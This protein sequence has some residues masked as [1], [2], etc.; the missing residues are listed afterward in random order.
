MII[1]TS[2]VLRKALGFFLLVILLLPLSA[3]DI[4]ISEGGSTTLQVSVNTYEQLRFSTSL[5]KISAYKINTDAGMF[6]ELVVPGYSNTYVPGSPKLPVSRKLIEFPVGASAEVNILS[7]RVEEFDLADLGFEFQLMPAQPPAPKDG[8]YVAFEYDAEAYARNAFTANELVSVEVLGTMRGIRIARVD[9]SPIQY[10][11][12]SGKL[13]VYSEIEAEVLFNGADVLATLAEK[14]KNDAPYFRS[15]GANLINYKSET[16][17]NRDT[18]TKYPVKY[19]IVSDPMFETQLQ[20][21]IQWKT[22]KGFTV[23]EAYTD[24]PAVGNTTNSIK[25][26]L[27]GLY[28]AG[29]SSD[30]APSFVLFVGDVGQIPAWSGNSG[31]HVTDLLYV[32]F[33]GDYFPEIY[34]GR[35]SATN[36]AELQPQIDKTLQYEQYTMPDPSY[37]DEVVLVAGM[38]ATFGNDWANGQINYGTENYFNIAHGLT[39]HTYLYPNSGSHSADI[40]QNVSDGVSF[41]NYTAHCSA[42]G[43]ADPS[44]VISDIAG[45]QNQD[46]YCVLIGNCC[47]SSEF[48]N[49]CFAEAILRAENKGAVGYIGG[50]NST[51][52][53]P[54]Y[55]FGVGVGTISEDPPSYEET[56]LGNYDRSFHDHGEPWEDWYTTTYQIIFAGNLAVTQGSPGS[57][58]YY[59]EI[60]CVMGDPSLECYFGVPDPPNVTYDPL[61]PLGTT[62]FTVNT[63]PYAYVGISKDGVLHGSALADANGIAVVTLDP[64][65]TPGT[66]DV[67]VTKQNTQPYIGTV[68]V[69]IPSGPYLV[70]S[71]HTIVDATGNNNGL[72]DYGESILLDVQLEN[73]GAADANNVEA[74][75]TSGDAYVSITDNFALWGT[76]AAGDTSTI[77]SAYSF[78]VH[79][80]VPDQHISAFDLEITGSG[81]DTWNASFNVVLNAP[82]LKSGEVSVD[83]SQAGNSNGRLDPGETAEIV[84]PLMNHGHCDASNTIS[85]LTTNNNH[86]VIN[87]GSFNVGSLPTSDTVN[88]VFSITVD[89][90]ITAGTSV[91]FEYTADADGYTDT[92][93]FFLIAGQTPVLIV[94]LDPNSSSSSAMTACLSN[95]GVGAEYVNV[96]PDELEMYSSVF[97]CLGIYSNNHQL[98]ADEGQA[99]AGYLNNGGNLYMEGGDTWYYDTQ[100]AVH[101]MFGI[102]GLSDG[103]DDLSSIQGQDGT[104]TE[105]MLYTYSGENNWID[106][107][108]PNGDAFMIFKNILPL[109]GTAVANIGPGYRTIGSSHEFGGLDDNEYTK[110]YLMFRYLEFFGIE[111]VWVGLDEVIADDQ[112][113]RVFPNPA[114]N[115]AG[116]FVTVQTAGEINLSIYNSTGQEVM[117]LADKAMVNPGKHEFVFNAA[118]LTGGIYY[119]VLT[120]GNLRI[121]KKI[122]IIK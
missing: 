102:T 87:S 74:T 112:S 45:L 103:S 77:N 9:I 4:I 80:L 69:D 8:S 44:F 62:A 40:I 16:S 35:W 66:A 21:F 30:P 86:V 33:T 92:L 96:I 109:Y 31:W 72:A 32:E 39:A 113:I 13:R 60:Y 15:V 22:K 82:V 17:A 27:Q 101:P 18:V 89:D 42:N 120:S 64:I 19:V 68:V 46:K 50:T 36:I 95:L 3:R 12:V 6:V 43:W 75:L 54:D 14:Q 78:D 90:D 70:L 106:Q 11:P 104:F 115:N 51:Y 52:W 110:D 79:A 34:F 119:C 2:D 53:D 55:Y 7:F 28:D 73:L 56:G 58:E 85:G 98:T 88:C 107:I 38:D 84:V 48:N 71:D 100:T 97:V 108:V 93:E 24:D 94:D 76:I 63:D 1:V 116:I 111:A 25:T 47:S 114:R 61:M 99:L 67:V 5:E 29:T 117:K 49:Y 81:K 122:V 59:W 65:Q 118:S 26:Y 41:G 20:P 57:A 10:N 37:L 121:S 23:I 91:Q 83:D 105:G